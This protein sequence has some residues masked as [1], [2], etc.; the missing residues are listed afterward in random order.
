[1]TLIQAAL[2][3]TLNLPMRY[4]ELSSLSPVVRKEVLT[5][6]LS[7]RI[8]DMQ[9]VDEGD[10]SSIVS[11][12]VNLSLS[13][14]LQTIE[15]PIRLHDQVESLKKNIKPKSTIGSKSPSPSASQDSGLDPNVGATASAP[16]HPSTPVSVSVGYSTPPR[17]S[18]PSGSLPPMSE[19]D[20]LFAAVSKLENS[21]QKEL[22]ELLMTLPKRERAMCLF[23]VEILRSK[24]V[25]AKMV[26]DSEDGE[27]EKTIEPPVAAVPSTP[28][29]KKTAA[30]T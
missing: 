23:N 7:R 28:V 21:R 1:L 15:D 3:G 8:R 4:D 14:V 11:S 6:D 13:E 29:T 24:L 18:S 2:S 30:M 12:L 5:G 10:V 17:T 25:D 20:R 9:I 16:E 19:K 27:E 26:L 22:T